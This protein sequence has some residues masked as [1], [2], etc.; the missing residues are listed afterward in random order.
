MNNKTKLYLVSIG[1]LVFVTSFIITFT[2]LDSSKIMGNI[3]APSLKFD[4]DCDKET[5][6]VNESTNCALVFNTGSYTATGIQGKLKSSSNLTISNVTRGDSWDQGDSNDVNIGYYGLGVTGNHEVATFT[7]TATSY[8]SGSITIGKDDSGFL[9]ISDNN[10]NDIELEEKTKTIQVTEPSVPATAPEFSISCN[11]GSVNIGESTTCTLSLNTGSYTATG[12]QGKLTSTNL[13]ISNVTKGDS[14]A[15]GDSNDVNIVYYGS[16]LTGNVEVASFTVTG[17][18]AGDGSIKIGKDDNNKLIISDSSFN[19]ID[20]EEKTKSITVNS[21]SEPVPL[22]SNNYLSSLSVSGGSLS[23][24]FNKLTNNYNVTLPAGTTVTT[25]SAS[26][27]DTK[28]RVSGTGSIDLIEGKNNKSVTVVAEDGTTNFYNITITVSSASSSVNTLGTLGINNGTLSPEFN[29]NVTLYSAS[30]ANSI[31]SITIVGTPTDSLATVTGLGTK[32]L[33][34]GENIFEVNVTAQ[35]GDKKTYT[36]KITR[37]AADLDDSGDNYLSTLTFTDGTLTPEFNR[38]ITNYYLVVDNN[39]TNVTIGGTSSDSKAT[40]NGLGKKQLS[41]GTAPYTINVTAADGSTRHYVVNITRKNI[42]S[43]LNSDASL[44]TLV[45]TG[46]TL[47]PEFN[48]DIYKYYLT[49][50]GSA[51]GVEVAAN[52]SKSTVTTEGKIGNSLKPYKIIVTAEDGT[53]NVYVISLKNTSPDIDADDSDGSIVK[54]CFITSKKYNVDEGKLRVDVINQNSIEAIRDN[55]SSTCGTISIDDS[56]IYLK[57]DNMTKVY[58][59]NKVFSPKTGNNIVSYGIFFMV[60]SSLFILSVIGLDKI[61][62]S[63]KM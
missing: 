18:T 36:L 24:D 25:I 7:V 62:R 6:D 50:T 56:Y 40:I 39:V 32:D 31:D 61:Y 29:S 33:S 43:G 21:E 27:E 47:E 42:D 60:I 53:K 59:I 2:N 26:A 51:V 41:V 11:K 55:I 19:D 5:L 63:K 38:E 14:W 17:V 58:K 23:P 10:Y 46:G 54:E 37:E 52:S 15:Q 12:V 49:I 45:I 22:S 13:S 48:K 3:I 35:N 4:F 28:A 20:V 8:G 9:I 16:G 44:K 34:V 1:F 30:V 57:Y